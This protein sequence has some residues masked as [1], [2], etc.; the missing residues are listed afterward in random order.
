MGNTTE[1]VDRFERST[2]DGARVLAQFVNG[3]A[4]LWVFGAEFV[5]STSARVASLFLGEVCVTDRSDL[6]RLFAE[7]RAADGAP[8]ALVALRVARALRAARAAARA[9]GVRDIRNHAHVCQ[10]QFCGGR[11]LPRGYVAAAPR[12]KP[13]VQW[14]AS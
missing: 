10:C 2:F 1:L 11:S 5:G 12:L 6:P 7:W 13:R 14:V 3:H 8:S 4:D 9:V